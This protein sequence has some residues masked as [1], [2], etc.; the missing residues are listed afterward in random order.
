MLYEFIKKLDA[1]V[2]FD[3][4]SAK[5]D[6]P[7]HQNINKDKLENSNRTKGYEYNICLRIKKLLKR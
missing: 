4:V 1:S 6:K 2:S 5:C 3:T 7:Y